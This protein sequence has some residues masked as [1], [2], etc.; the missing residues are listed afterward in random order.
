MYPIAYSFTNRNDPYVYSHFKKSLCVTFGQCHPLYGIKN[1]KDVERMAR[2]AVFC[3][4][5][6]KSSSVDRI[7]W[8]SKQ[9]MLMA[10]ISGYEGKPFLVNTEADCDYAID[11]DSIVRC[12]NAFRKSNF[13]S[14]EYLD[15]VKNIYGAIGQ[16][17]C[18][19]ANSKEPK[20]PRQMHSE[21][22][23]FLVNEI[24]EHFI[25][26]AIATEEE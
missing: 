10:Q 16:I 13:E 21:I 26:N 9:E 25:K 14:V 12:L 20:T 24:Y 7:T 8:Y 18:T 17:G 1:Y 15:K 3:D 19:F 11:I 23:T 5:K 4:E 6:Y 22:R 2:I